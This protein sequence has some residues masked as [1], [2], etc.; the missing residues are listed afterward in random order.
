MMRK[1]LGWTVLEL[2]I[3][4]AIVILIAAIVY[5]VGAF[6]IEKGRQSRCIS[7]LRQIGIAL[8]QYIED[9]KISD[10]N[11]EISGLS[12]AELTSVPQKWRERWGF[13]AS[14]EHL[15]ENGYLGDSALLLC[16]SSSWRADD[17]R[18]TDYIYHLPEVHPCIDGTRLD[19]ILFLKN[20]LQD[21]PVVVDIMHSAGEKRHF[22]ILRMNLKVETRVLLL[23]EWANLGNSLQL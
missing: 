18:R 20:R 19:A 5:G 12:D 4:C 7:N 23:E 22:I 8:H 11:P 16:S 17:Q 3:V 9:Y 13:P 6:A 15:A 2:L 14:L 21:Y 1:K 10:W